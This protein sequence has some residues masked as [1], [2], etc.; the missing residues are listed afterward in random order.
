M[1]IRSRSLVRRSTWLLVGAAC[2]AGLLSAPFGARGAAQTQGVDDSI[3]STLWRTWEEGG[4]TIVDGLANV[5]LS[6][7]RAATDKQYRFELSVRDAA[8]TILFRD[9]W[10]RE[11]TERATASTADDVAIQEAFRFGV[12]P[13]AYEVDLVAYALETPDMHARATLTLEGF[14]ERPG[15]SDLFLAARVDRV[16]EMGTGDWSIVHGEV[17]IAGSAETVV[18]MSQ[19]EIFYFMELYPGSPETE[20]P[21]ATSVSVVAEILGEAGNVLLR[22]PEQTVSF[23]SA[24]PFTGRLAL[25]GLPPG[26]YRLAMQVE[27]PEGSFRRSSGFRAAER[28]AVF[29]GDPASGPVGLYLGS[30]S[31]EELDARF[32]AIELVVSEMEREL[33]LELPP[34][35]KRRYLVE[36]FGPKDPDPLTERNEFFD[37]FVA[38]VDAV[39]SRFDEDPGI[40]PWKTARGR[41]YLEYGEPSNRVAQYFPADEGFATTNL[42]SP[43]FAGEP[44]YEIWS[45]QTT[46]FVYLFVMENRFGA[47][48]LIY[49]TDPEIAH[50]ADWTQRV[51]NAALR[52]LQ[53]QF[54]VRPRVFE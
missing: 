52:D 17:G 28:R 40:P 26:E 10:V 7:L 45:Y 39:Y 41:V 16:G 38:R 2:S 54:G 48:R 24:Q 1:S 20:S 12:R 5:P 30:L 25:D 50:V 42:G 4:V 27:G 29:A 43:S 31:D 14:A 51:G 34:D 6:I 18:L 46:G 19:P 35:G 49:S 8:G 21:E 33:Y 47:W 32:G 36:F 9:S 23:S 22:T 37:E 44:P 53:E 3:A 15:A 13:G 11:L